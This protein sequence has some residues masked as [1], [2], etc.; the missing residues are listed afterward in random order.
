LRAPIYGNPELQPEAV[1]TAEA[2]LEQSFGQTITASITGFQNQTTNLI[3]FDGNSSRYYNVNRA[4]IKGVES[5]VAWDVTE[6]ISSGAQ[7]TH[8]S[9]LDKETNEPLP[10]RPD[11]TWSGDVTW[12]QNEFSWMTAVRGQT[13]SRARPY[14]DGTKGFRVVDTALGWRQGPARYSLRVNNVLNTWYQEVAGYNTAARSVL[15]SVE[16]SF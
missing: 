10:S 8:I 11:D 2:G 9:S 16:F 6:S 14:V 4:L 3:E 12:K 5:K 15:G 7:Y 1:I 13:R